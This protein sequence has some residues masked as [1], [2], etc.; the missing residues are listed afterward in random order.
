M[1]IVVTHKF[2][3]LDALASL[4]AARRLYD[5]AAA[6]R[7]AQVSEL[8]QRYLAL[9]KDA[10]PLTAADDVD[11]SS[12]ETAIVVDSRKHSRL[13]EFTDHLEA[14]DRVVV[15]DHH[16]PSADDIPADEVHVEPVGA[17]VTLLSEELRARDIELTDREATLMLLGLYADTGRLSFESTT[18][19]DVEAGAH[20][21]RSGAKLP[22]VNRYLRDQYELEERKLLAELMFNTRDLDIG[23]A[24]V[25]LAVV[26]IDDY[27]EGASS[28]VQ[29]LVDMDGPE[30]MFAVLGFEGGSRVQL[31]ARSRVA[32]IDVSEVAEQFGGGGH[33]SAAAAYCK[34]KTLEEVEAELTAMLESMEMDPTV[35]RDL[36]TSPVETIPREMSLEEAKERFE[37]WEVT[38]APV[39]EEG[40]VDGIVSRRDIERAEQGD[41]LELPVSSHMSQEPVTVA[42][43]LS[44]EDALEMMTER[45]IGRL[46]ILEDGRLIGIVSRSDLLDSM[47]GN[48]AAAD[49][50]EPTPTN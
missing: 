16:P 21:L 8:S 13:D 1:D 6:L 27:V 29:H 3:D 42:P 20:L 41:R 34:D 40:E 25:S 44:L 28:V 11:P 49:Q 35:V 36:M 46:P 17:C 30:A 48:E 10:L 23:S 31:I 7:N 47:Y 18:A 24:T 39:I 12:V 45:D 9:H 37:R 4:V 14:A 2:A 33:P 22:V 32:Y 5:G 15:Y 38:G 43:D 26:E 19:R 50:S